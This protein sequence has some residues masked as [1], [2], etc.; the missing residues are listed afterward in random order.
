MKSDNEINQCG[1]E[2]KE[3]AINDSSITHTYKFIEN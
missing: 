1:N 2:L 3:M